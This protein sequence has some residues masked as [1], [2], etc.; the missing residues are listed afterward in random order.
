MYYGVDE[1]GNQREENPLDIDKAGFRPDAYMEKVLRECSLNELYK[2]E[3]KMK[4]G[5]RRGGWGGGGT[6]RKGG[7]WGKGREWAGEVGRRRD[8]C[9]D[10]LGTCPVE[11]KLGKC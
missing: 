11:K 2:Q 9:Q 5:G 7:G 10:V 8:G 4:K 1:H 6:W 3:G